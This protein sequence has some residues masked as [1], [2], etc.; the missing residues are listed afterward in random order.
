M[1]IAAA[2]RSFDCVEATDAA[3]AA[4]DDVSRLSCRAGGDEASNNAIPALL[5]CTDPILATDCALVKAH[6]REP[7]QHWMP[8]ACGAL[9]DGLPGAA[10]TTGGSF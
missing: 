10:G 4:H 1:A 6:P 7:V 2:Q 9:L 3:N 5:S 8:P